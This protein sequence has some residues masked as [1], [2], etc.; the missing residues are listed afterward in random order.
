[1]RR[2]VLW[3]FVI[4]IAGLSVGVIAQG[5][6]QPPSADAIAFAQ[7]ASDLMTNT[8]VAALVQEIGE[9]TP[10]NVQEGSLSIGL[11][12]NDKNSNMRLVGTF[13][14]LEADNVP[15][16]NFESAALASALTGQPYTNVERVSGT[17]YYRRSIPLSNFVPQCAMCHANFASLASTEW[18]GALMLKVPIAGK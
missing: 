16:D 15:Q 18:V 10:A 8:V 2:F 1:M 13:N 17:W 3:S 9:T 11:V 4:G 12:F 5:N 14:P 7:R 6:N